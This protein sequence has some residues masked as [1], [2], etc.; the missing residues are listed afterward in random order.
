[1]LRVLL[2]IAEAAG[3]AHILIVNTYIFLALSLMLRVLS[4]IAEAAGNVR[5]C[6]EPPPA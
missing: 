5:T 3:N 4:A 1:M 6:S 2:A